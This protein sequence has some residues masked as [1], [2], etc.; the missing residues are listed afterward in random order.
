MT[1]NP[2]ISF[3]MTIYYLLSGRL[4]FPKNR[5]GEIFVTTD[6]CNF[7]IFRQAVVNPP[8]GQNCKKPG[9]ILRVRFRITSMTPRQNEIFSLIPIPFITGLPGFRSK[10]WMSDRKTGEC[11]G[12]YVWDSIDSA[13][14]YADSF[15]MRFMS[16]RA[17]PGSVWYRISPQ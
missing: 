6:G 2:L 15:A 16:S 1:F 11:Q 9:A 4:H 8:A 17:A 7:T 12:V 10:L 5:S 3:F 13:Q 14:R